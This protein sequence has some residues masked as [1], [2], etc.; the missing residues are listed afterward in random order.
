MEKYIKKQKIL[1]T[2]LLLGVAALTIFLYALFTKQDRMQAEVFAAKT[3][4]A[5][6]ASADRISSAAVLRVAALE[7]RTQALLAI[8]LTKDTIPQFLSRLE[9][10]AATEGVT[11]EVSTVEVQSRDAVPVLTL[12]FSVKGQQDAV[13]QFLDL[14]QKQKEVMRF[15]QLMVGLAGT[16]TNASGILEVVSFK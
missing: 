10:L 16:A 4:L 15:A 11:I 7:A 3:T 1:L 13:L 2:T 9:D 14:L 6:I 8:P 12:A 5:E